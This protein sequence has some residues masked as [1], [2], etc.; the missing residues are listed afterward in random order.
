MATVTK[1]EPGQDQKLGTS[2]RSPTYE[3]GTQVLQPSSVAFPNALAGNWIGSGV[4]RT[5]TS[6]E[7][8]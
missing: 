4:A 3:A 1:A 8:W 7:F 5:Q 2:L 6:K